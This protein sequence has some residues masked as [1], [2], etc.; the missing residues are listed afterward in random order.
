MNVSGYVFAMALVAGGAEAQSTIDQHCGEGAIN[1]AV[2]LG[3][4]V[5]NPDGYYV[6]SLRTQLSHGDARIRQAVGTTFFLCTRS[7]ATPDM[8]VSGISNAAG[9]NEITYLFVPTACPRNIP[10][11]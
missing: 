3:D 9:R 2:S 11:S 4:V 5:A 1:Q 7:A 6:R 8:D 10:G